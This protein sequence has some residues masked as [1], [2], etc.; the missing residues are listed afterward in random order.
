MKI[1]TKPVL[2][3]VTTKP[4]PALP[5]ATKK[6]VAAAAPAPTPEKKQRK[7]VEPGST[8]DKYRKQRKYTQTSLLQVFAT[9]V[10][11]IRGR[12]KTNRQKPVKG[13]A[14]ISLAE[15][16]AYLICI[17]SDPPLWKQAK[18]TPKK[19]GP[20]KKGEPAAVVAPPRVAN[21]KAVLHM[22]KLGTL[23]PK[24][25]PGLSSKPVGLSGLR[26]AS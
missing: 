24:A 17:E 22:A 23:G 13:V 18:G 20:K 6:S 2:R 4:K 26:K 12:L 16:I 25:K 10:E 14:D 7:P 8:L 11:Q 21:T 15:A 1:K 9:P 5:V 19:R 3:A